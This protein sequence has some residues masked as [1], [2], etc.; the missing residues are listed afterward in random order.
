MSLDLKLQSPRLIRFSGNYTHNG[1]VFWRAA[2]VYEALYN[3]QNQTAAFWLEVLEAGLECMKRNPE[4]FKKLNPP[5]GWGDYDSAVAF[6]GS[7]VEACKKYPKAIIK[8]YR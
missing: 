4:I 8:S 7:F 3:P 2:G 5:S 1:N 6:L